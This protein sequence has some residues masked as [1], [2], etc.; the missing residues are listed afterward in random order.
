MERK[1]TK[2][3]SNTDVRWCQGL[4][5]QDLFSDNP[6]NFY[7]LSTSLHNLSP[8]KQ[9]WYVIKAQPEQVAMKHLLFSLLE[10]TSMFQEGNKPTCGP[11]ETMPS[12]KAVQSISFI[13]DTVG[14]FFFF[15]PTCINSFFLCSFSD[16]IFNLNKSYVWRHQAH[17]F[18]VIYPIWIAYNWD[19][20]SQLWNIFDTQCLTPNWLLRRSNNWL[21]NL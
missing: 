6:A 18:T 20:F 12:H 14:S 4:L 3:G 7:I 15:F 17:P 1:K 5:S 19:Q 13:K 9:F 8:N 10:C 11:E 2:T 16:L 21:L